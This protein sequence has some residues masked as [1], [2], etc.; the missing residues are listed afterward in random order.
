MYFLFTEPFTVLVHALSFGRQAIKC[1]VKFPLSL[2][3]YC[4]KVD[5]KANGAGKNVWKFKLDTV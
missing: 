3:R 2:N 4:F 5:L 1:V